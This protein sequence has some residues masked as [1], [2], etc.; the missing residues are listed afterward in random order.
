[1]TSPDFR[2]Y[3]DLTIYDTTPQDLYD[4]AV[5]YAQTALSEFEP[6]LGMVEDAILQSM[7]YVGALIAVSINDKPPAHL[8]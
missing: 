8:D 6:R 2:E 3:I 5:V 4:E 1:M 7:A